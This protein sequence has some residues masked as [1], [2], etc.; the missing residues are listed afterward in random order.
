MTDKADEIAAIAG[1][2]TA[3]QTRCFN[4]VAREHPIAI[5]AEDDRLSPFCDD[6][7]PTDTIN[8]CF[9]LGIID[10]LGRGDFDDFRIVLTP[11]GLAVRNH[12]KGSS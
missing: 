7:S 10:Q 1:E 2:L 8:Q 3:A 12:L 9:D 4:L 11:L 6:V 5:P